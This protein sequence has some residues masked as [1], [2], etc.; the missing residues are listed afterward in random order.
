MSQ[1]SLDY[2]GLIESVVPGGF[3]LVAD[4][5]ISLSI[6]SVNKQ[7][8]YVHVILMEISFLLR[9]LLAL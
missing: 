1:I 9:L 7:E 5:L 3:I 2:K 6:I 8:G 4:G